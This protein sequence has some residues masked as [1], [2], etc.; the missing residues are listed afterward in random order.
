[1]LCLCDIRFTVRSMT[2][3]RKAITSVWRWNARSASADVSAT[4]A[5]GEEQRGADQSYGS[6][7]DIHDVWNGLTSSEPKLALAWRGAVG[8]SR[9]HFGEFTLVS[10]NL[11]RRGWAYS[12]RGSSGPS[13]RARSDAPY[14]K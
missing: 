9:F 12:R 13:R 1:M 8:P 5:T 4:H 7:K 10:A 6:S 11:A 3:E 14:R 2:S